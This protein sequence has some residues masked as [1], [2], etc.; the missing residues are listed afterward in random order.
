MDG[1]EVGLDRSEICTLG[2]WAEPVTGRVITAH[3]RKGKIYCDVMERTLLYD[4]RMEEPVQIS[5]PPSQS[6]PQRIW[7]TV[8]RTEAGRRIVGAAK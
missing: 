7:Q 8:R 4:E 6:P 5:L 3:G 1:L 2:G